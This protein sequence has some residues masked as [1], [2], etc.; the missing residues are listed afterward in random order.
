MKIAI[1]GVTGFVGVHLND[2]LQQSG[3]E[4][5]AV[6]RNHFKFSVLNLSRYLQGVDA[7]INL[8]GS[9]VIN[10]WTKKNR[11]IILQS[12]VETTSKL[13]EAISVMTEKPNIFINASAIG[14]YD[15]VNLHSEHSEMFGENFLSQVV[16]Q[17]EDAAFS[18]KETI[19]RVCIAR[20]GVVF[21]ADGGAF[22]KLALPFK[23]G[24]GGRIGNGKQAVSFIHINDVVRAFEHLLTS[25]SASGIYNFT[26]PN[27]TTNGEMSKA[28]AT[29]LGKPMWFT[30]PLAMLKIVYGK[31]SQVIVGGEK[32]IPKRLLDEGFTFNFPDITTTVND[33]L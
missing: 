8:S 3:H 10:R 2:Y 14:I 23:W 19:N 21:G 17:W 32:V 26:A 33:L 25:N 4:V 31:A 9:P 20:L 30:V 6:T 15:Y 27:Y 29:S 22:P 1:A 12:R 16:Q 11:A 18:A 28:L 5:V 7:V 24:V 13:V